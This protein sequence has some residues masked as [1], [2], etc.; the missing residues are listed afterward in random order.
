MYMKKSLNKDNGFKI[1]HN[2]KL[3]WILIF[4]II[5]LIVLVFFIVKNKKTTSNENNNIPV[6]ECKKDSD[7]IKMQTGCCPCNM[8]G[9]EICV[10]SSESK[11]YLDLLRN[12]D[13]KIIC[14]AMYACSIKSC[15][16]VNNK[17]QSINNPN[18]NGFS[19]VV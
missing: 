2:K 11:K 18:D 1:H 7:C 6:N 3:F 5:L 16:C 4:F 15:I 8:G 12:C 9:K 13:K 10:S 14:T 19:P 17:C